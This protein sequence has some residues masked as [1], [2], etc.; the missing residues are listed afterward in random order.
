L[1]QHL[2]GEPKTYAIGT[3]SY[4]YTAP[5]DAWGGVPV[6]VEA[7]SSARLK[8]FIEFPFE[9]LRVLVTDSAGRPV[10][11]ATIRVRDRM[12]ES[13]RQVEE[14]PMQLE[15]AAH[16]IPYPAA[17]R[18]TGGK[19]ILPR[20]REGRLDLTVELDNGPAYAFTVPVP[21]TRQLN[22]KLGPR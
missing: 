17:A 4:K 10:E 19:A 3:E 6:H 15:Q 20:I 7:N 12:S 18:I 5:I 11:H 22:L 21:P 8:D 9:N 14:N 13:W 2:I 1:F 16:P